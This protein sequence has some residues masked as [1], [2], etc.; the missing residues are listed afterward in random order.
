MSNRDKIM[1][2][3]KEIIIQNGFHGCSM[4]QIVEESGV[5]TGGVYYHFESKDEIINEIYLTIKKDALRALHEYAN[6]E[7]PTRVFIKDLWYGKVKWAKNN[8]CSKR[9]LDMFYQ[10]PY[11]HVKVNDELAQSYQ[12]LLKRVRLA[13][14]NGEIIDMDCGFFFADI[15]A[16]TNVVL[17]YLAKYPEK[18][19][20]AFLDFAFKKYWRSIVN[21]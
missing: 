21:I 20:E 10:S 17:N 12:S 1:Q 6:L 8:S 13:V 19:E 15:D 3:A 4:K 18:D 7:D 16:S 14:D 5:S 11:K 9:F 2:T